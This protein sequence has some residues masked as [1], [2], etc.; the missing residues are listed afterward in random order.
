MFLTFLLAFSELFSVANYPGDQQI[1]ALSE[2][3]RR[4]S[5]SF[6]ILHSSTSLETHKS[7]HCPLRA[8]N[9]NVSAATTEQKGKSHLQGITERK[10]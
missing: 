8:A 1:L 4:Q 3:R 7:E 5:R 10:Y 2:R 9:S 6:L